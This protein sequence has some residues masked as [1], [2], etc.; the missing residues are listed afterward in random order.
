MFLKISKISQENACAEFLLNNNVAGRAATLLKKKLQHKCFL[1]NFAKFL[2]TLLQN[3][4]EEV[5]ALKF[6]SYITRSPLDAN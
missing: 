3:T 4:T 6:G 2:R 5:I 1:V